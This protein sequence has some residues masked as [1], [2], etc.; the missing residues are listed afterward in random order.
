MK[1]TKS[2]WEI[3]AEMP[4]VEQQADQDT[5]DLNEGCIRYRIRTMCKST[6]GL[7]WGEKSD[8]MQECI[9]FM[10]WFQGSLEQRAAWVFSQHQNM[11]ATMQGILAALASQIIKLRSTIDKKD[12]DAPAPKGLSFRAARG[13]PLKLLISRY[14]EMHPGVRW[15]GGDVI[16]AH[17]Q[18]YVARV[19][20]HAVVAL[21]DLIIDSAAEAPSE[22]L[23]DI[24]PTSGPWILREHSWMPQERT[25][26]KAWLIQLVRELGSNYLIHE[27]GY[28]KKYRKQDGSQMRFLAVEN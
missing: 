17:D 9:L 16:N 11:P 8:H 24:E 7:I 20:E 18:G 28:L 19:Y 6:A 26:L 23:M 15:Q 25:D 3:L 27:P 5:E 13:L 10:T 4:D 2:L 12:A 22:K 21:F 14:D 1:R